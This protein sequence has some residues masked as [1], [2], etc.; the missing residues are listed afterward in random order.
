MFALLEASTD[1]VVGSAMAFALSTVEFC[2][3]YAADLFPDL[4]CSRPDPVSCVCSARL[5]VALAALSVSFP[6]RGYYFDSCGFGSPRP[7]CNRNRPNGEIPE[8]AI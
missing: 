1:P 8:R 5:P 2:H 3:S 6:L 4:F 7:P